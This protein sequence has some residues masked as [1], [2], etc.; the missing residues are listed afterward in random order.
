MAY[1]SGNLA[2]GFSIAVAAHVSMCDHCRSRLASYDAVGGALF[3]K[4]I[5]KAVDQDT[6]SKTLERI[7]S[8]QPVVQPKA[9][10]PSDFPEPLSDYVGHK[11]H[12]IKWQ[13]LGMGIKQAVLE[14]SE[15]ATARLLYIPAGAQMPDHSHRGLELTLVLD[16]A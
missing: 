16:G 9:K 12:D 4:D 8:F 10:Q 15:D 13:P 3:E 11:L 5:D 7:K 2:E 1:A 14:T 6:F